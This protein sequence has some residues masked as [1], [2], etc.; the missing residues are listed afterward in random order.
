[1][2]NY[3]F[4]LLWSKEDNGYIVT[5]PDFPGLSAFGESPEEALS[6]A[7]IALELFIESLQASGDELPKPTECAEYS[8]QVRLRMP[9]T[10]HASLVHKAEREGVSL[11]TWLIT[12]LSERNA[13]STLV[14]RVCE[15]ID[16]VESAINN[17]SA[18]TKHLT[19]SQ[20]AIYTPDISQGRDHA[21]I[22]FSTH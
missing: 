9:K 21:K 13:T 17:H 4:N 15:K 2:P 20:N 6:E 14:D 16:K 18:E 19:F 22:T 10:L 1:V 11:N 12:L 3:G 7:R 8:G 5:C